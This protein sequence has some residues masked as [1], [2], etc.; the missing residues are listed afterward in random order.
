VRDVFAAELIKLSPP[1]LAALDFSCSR[2]L[3]HLVLSPLGACPALS[4]LAL[5][6]CA[7]LEHVLLQSASLR[8]LDLNSCVSLDQVGCAPAARLPLASHANK[9]ASNLIVLS[10]TIVY[11]IVMTEEQ[12]PGTER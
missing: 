7:A 6:G 4:S 12:Q 5:A 10:R 3:R 2:H 8:R 11:S 1:R 9:E